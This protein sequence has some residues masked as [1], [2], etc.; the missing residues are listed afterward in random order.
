MLDYSKHTGYTKYSSLEN[1]VVFITGGATGIGAALVEAFASQQAKVAFVDIDKD[2][3]VV[4][5]NALEKKGFYRPFF[6]ECDV[7][8]IT[9]IQDTITRIQKEIGGINVLINNAANDQRY[10]TATLA[11]HEWLQ[12]LSINLHP[13]FF[14]AQAVLPMMIAAGGGAILN[15]SSIN[16]KFAPENLVSYITAK[17]GLIGMSKALAKEMGVHN[18]RVNTLL[19][20]WVATP[21]QLEK[22]LTDQEEKKLV[23]RMCIKKRLAAHDVAKLALFLASDDALMITAQEFVVDGGRM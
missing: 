21:K 4:L 12:S 20:G 15:I 2:A 5:C 1:K 18:I 22:W 16:V 7:S 6:V 19:P 10:T 14:T 13:A 9:L 17:A 3:A 11:E 8:N 23:D